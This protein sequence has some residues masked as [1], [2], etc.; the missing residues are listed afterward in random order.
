MNNKL[1]SVLFTF[2]VLAI[3][4]SFSACTTISNGSN[5]LQ[6]AKSGFKYTVDIPDKWHTE[7]ST[8]LSFYT[9]INV[10]SEDGFL[11]PI[12]TL[13]KVDLPNESQDFFIKK[14]LEGT[15]THKE[16]NDIKNSKNY[17]VSAY[18]CTQNSARKE[19]TCYFAFFKTDTDFVI[20]NLMGD[21]SL[22]KDLKLYF[23]KF[24][25]TFRPA[26]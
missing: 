23:Y 13:T 24:V 21:S 22:D 20:M 6:P 1:S 4:A 15:Q 26:S 19:Y 10:R 16:L 11:N 7:S 8:D 12:L 9:S 18:E 3:C 25:K 2:I 14:V 17:S 5:A